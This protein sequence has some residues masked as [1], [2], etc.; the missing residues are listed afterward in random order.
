MKVLMI[1]SVCGIKSTGR[2][3][4]DLAETLEREGHTCKIAY[5]REGVPEKYKN[6]AVKI[7]TDFS[8]KSDA[9]KTRLFDS[10][11]FNSKAATRRFIKWVKEYDPEIIHLH[12]LHGYYI[13]VKIL[14]DYLRTS[15]KRV[16][17][18][19]H[20]C[21]SFTGH[22]CHFVN[23]NCENWKTSCS[24]CPKTKSYPKSLVDR[25]AANYEK[26]KRTF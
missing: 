26:K 6:Y 10:A 21:W 3:C 7:G 22:C 9:L 23:V 24:S 25:S 5:G 11:G 18:T 19:L 15:K 4:T 2:I 20:D 1:N 16:I 12:N 13:N 8:V 17:W 14:F